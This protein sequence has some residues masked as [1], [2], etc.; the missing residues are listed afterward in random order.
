MTK[1]S[2]LGV[3]GIRHS[4]RTTLLRAFSP[5]RRPV[6]WAAAGLKGAPPPRLHWSEGAAA[7]RL[8][9]AIVLIDYSRIE[10]REEVETLLVAVRRANA[11]MVRVFLN[12]SDMSNS[13]DAPMADVVAS[14]ARDCGEIWGAPLRC[15]ALSGLLLGQAAELASAARAARKVSTPDRART[16]LQSVLGGGKLARA[17]PFDGATGARLRSVERAVEGGGGTADDAWFVA[18]LAARF[19]GGMALGAAIKAAAKCDA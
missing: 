2:L 6:W 17:V 9:G 14:V 15:E 10:A 13:E 16:A 5:G 3:F 7:A 12:K 1:R 18:S 19:G 4:R 11:R 8:D